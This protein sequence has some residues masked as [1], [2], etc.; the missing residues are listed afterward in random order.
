M[1]WI[2]C[3]CVVSSM[4][5]GFALAAQ[6]E[7]PF[8]RRFALPMG[9]EL[10]VEGKEMQCF[11]GPE[12]TTII[13]INTAYGHLY[14]WRLAAMSTMD[15]YDLTVASRD[16]TILELKGVIKTLK[17]DRAW[18]TLRLDQSK[19]TISGQASGFRFEKYALWFLVLAETVT[20]AVLS[21]K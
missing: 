14:D 3:L 20:I 2:L 18:L 19:E 10:T 12:Y 21:F 4:L 13:R 16:K 11:S 9:Q 7:G 17:D 8:D 5:Y 15:T 6:E 1:R